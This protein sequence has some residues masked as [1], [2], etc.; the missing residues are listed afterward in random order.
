MRVQDELLH[1]QW[2]VIR[3]LPETIKKIMSNEIKRIDDIDEIRDDSAESGLLIQALK[4]KNKYGLGVLKFYIH[5]VYLP[6]I[7][8]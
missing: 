8:E 3:V 5:A 1:F 2:A 4:E 7:I 6:E